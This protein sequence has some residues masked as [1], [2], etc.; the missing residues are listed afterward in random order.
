MGTQGGMMIILSQT[1]FLRLSMIACSG[2]SSRAIDA[3]QVASSAT[4][5]GGTSVTTLD[6]NA[7]IAKPL[8]YDC[9]NGSSITN[10]YRQKGTDKLI[11]Q[12]KSFGHEH[13]QNAA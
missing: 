13:L 9:H 12:L 11:H 10:H 8:K 4:E 3:Q 2:I 6:A 5:Y 1:R 7:A